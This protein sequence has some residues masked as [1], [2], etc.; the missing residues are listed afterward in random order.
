MDRDA[1]AVS[2][3]S[4]KIILLYLADRPDEHNVVLQNAALEDQGGK[5][6]I[7][8]EFAESTSANDWAAGVQTAV[9]WDRVEQYLVFDSIEE[10]FSRI[11]LGMENKTLQ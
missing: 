9:A 3:F 8:G 11:T 6:F 1:M 5:V 4:G 7:V 10:Y 2:D